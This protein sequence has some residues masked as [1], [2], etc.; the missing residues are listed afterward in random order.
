MVKRINLKIVRSTDSSTNT[1]ECK[2]HQELID[3]I[4]EYLPEQNMQIKLTDF[5]AEI[6]YCYTQADAKQQALEYLLCS[7]QATLDSTTTA[8]IVTDRKGN[9]TRLNHKATFLLAQLRVD[10][11]QNIFTQLAPSI[12]DYPDVLRSFS[13]VFRSGQARTELVVTL[14][15]GRIFEIVSLPQCVKG[16]V[17]GRVWNITEVTKLRSKERQ[18]YFMAYHDS[19]TKLPNRLKLTEHLKTAI[20][21]ATETRTRLAVIFIDLD[22]F[23]YVNDTLGHD[24]GDVLLIEAAR[25]IEAHLTSDD[26]LSRHGGDEFILLLNNI[27]SDAEIA[28]RT[29]A[30]R[31]SLLPVVTIAGQEA[32]VSGSIGVATFPEH[33]RDYSSLI[34]HAD[35]AMYQAKRLGR[36]NCQFF[37]SAYALDGN[38]RM[39]LITKL[40]KAVYNN[41]I[42]TVYQPIIDVV[43]C[44]ITALE[45]TFKWRQRDGSFI[46]LNDFLSIAIDTELIIPMTE[47]II[48]QACQQ[49]VLWN[50]L[51]HDHLTVTFNLYPAHFKNTGLVAH[52]TNAL[53]STG[54][55]ADKLVFQIKDI[56]TAVQ[57]DSSN[58]LLANLDRL[59]VQIIASDFGCSVTSMNHFTTLPISGVKLADDCVANVLKSDKHRLLVQALIA[60]SKMMDFTISASGITNLGQQKLLERYGCSVMQGSLFGPPQNSEL[61]ST[62]L[63]KQLPELAP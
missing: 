26:L 11:P 62:K 34:K 55:G 40:K 41:E 30:I 48:N 54:L 25:R 33:G 49:M 22:G 1:R 52:I 53:K 29:E 38:V 3:Q 19:L 21:Q 5:I 32:Y 44:N 6:D 35:L 60:M 58:E 37:T 50:E 39:L 47:R 12:V 56:E 8:I 2:V 61:I 57:Y 24:S 23:K 15:Y 27:A 7:A 51:G 4:A 20:S 14:T 46:P 42:E 16:A 18:V 9:V 43:N 31:K 13:Q 63:F 10:E 17:I 36:N 59:G 45:A 28:S